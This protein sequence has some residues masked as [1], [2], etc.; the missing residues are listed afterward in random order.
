MSNI[1][2]I[3]SR[4]QAMEE[5]RN[6]PELVNQAN[7]QSLV[8]KTLNQLNSI[9]RRLDDLE[10]QGFAGRVWGAIT[11]SNQRNMVSL[12][13]DLADSQ[14]TTVKLVLTLAVYHAQNAAVMDGVIGELE[15]AKGVNTRSANHIAFLYEQ[16]QLIRESALRE[17]P[18]RSF[19]GIIIPSTVIAI[20]VVVY[21]FLMILK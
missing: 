13:R 11:G 18:H 15:R 12:M 8:Q 21:M 2:P 4:Q 14:Q 7:V 19:K 9:E 1:V 16:V 3:P 6:N 17:K 5:V 10:N 20:L